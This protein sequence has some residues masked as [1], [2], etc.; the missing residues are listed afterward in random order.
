MFYS[1]SKNHASLHSFVR[2]DKRSLILDA[3]REAPC[4]LSSCSVCNICMLGFQL[5][6]NVARTAR[7]TNFAL[8]YGKGTYFSS[9]SGKA[10]DYATRSAK[11]TPD[12]YEG[13]EVILSVG[14]A[15]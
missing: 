3:Q 4:G 6:N 10:N 5:R 7:A 2:P 11:V 8:R 1:L 12:F 13:V 15:S 14:T 9:V